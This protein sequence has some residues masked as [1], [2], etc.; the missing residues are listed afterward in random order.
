VLSPLESIPPGYKLLAWEGVGLYV[1]PRWDIG[2]HEGDHRRGLFRVDDESRVVIQARWWT[3]ERPVPIDDLVRQHAGTVHGRRSGPPPRFKR[4]DGLGLTPGVDERAVAFEAD[5]KGER[6]PADREILVVWQ[7]Q[8][9]GRVLLLRFLI[10]RGSPGTGCIRTMLTGLRLQGADEARD[11]AALD[12]A[13][14]CPAGYVLDTGILKAGVCYVEFRQGR[15]RLALRRFSAA[16]AV[17]GVES[18]CLEDLD[19]WC[20][21]I[22]ASEF[23]DMRYEV[24]RTTDPAGRPLLRLTGR[25]RWLAPIEMRWLIPRHRRL[26]RRI[27]IVWDA[28]ANKIYCIELL[29]PGADMEAAVTAFEWS[30]RITLG[31][32]PRTGESAGDGDVGAG[33]T[34][35]RQRRRRSL[36]A[37]V[38]RSVSATVEVLEHGRTALG[39]TVERPRHL[40]FLRLLGGL[41]AGPEKQPRTVELDLIGSLV[42]EECGRDR[43]VCEIIDLVRDRFRISH[44]EAELSVTEFIRGLG[45]RGLLSVV[46][47]P[48]SPVQAQMTPENSRQGPSCRTVTRAVH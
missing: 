48:D 43:R 22:Y 32:E 27:D 12:F 11:F 35:A 39:Y 37:R 13:V 44:R 3:A 6:T 41:P 29:R 20:R 30:A 47:E 40:R 36:R 24:A 21:K 15:R 8:S 7:K 28:G 17:M 9:I 1:P 4:V 45:S 16:N 34:E 19:R 2:R 5:V 18:P 10:E 14:Q 42:W 46:L 23:H 38:Q 26:P 25:R 33:L 31:P